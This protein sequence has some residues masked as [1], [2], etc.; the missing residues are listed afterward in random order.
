MLSV[1]LLCL[2]IYVEAIPIGLEFGVTLGLIWGDGWMDLGNTSSP[3][4]C[5]GHRRTQVIIFA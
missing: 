2:V 1:D 5:Y 4:L 3:Q